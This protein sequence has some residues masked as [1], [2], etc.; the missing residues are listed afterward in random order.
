MSYDL[1]HLHRRGPC[2]AVVGTYSIKQTTWF[3]ALVVGSKNGY[4]GVKM[5]STMFHVCQVSHTYVYSI[6][7]IN[8]ECLRQGRK[9]ST[10]T[11]LQAIFNCLKL[12]KP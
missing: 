12:L 4:Y 5:K 11:F 3:T 6:C 2:R 9:L 7:L 10:V 1:K 8:N